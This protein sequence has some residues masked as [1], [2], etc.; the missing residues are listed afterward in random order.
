MI[1]KDISL[2][3]PQENILYDEVLLQLAEEGKSD[4]V[5]RFWESKHYF[6]V[7]GRTCDEN[8]D[9]KR[10]K[11]I[12]DGIPV[13][14]RSSGGGTVIQGPGCLNYSFILSKQKTPEIADLHQSYVYILNKVVSALN[15]LGRNCAFYP[16]S[17]IALTQDRKKVSGNAQKRGR[18]CILHHGT[19]LYYFDLNKIEQYL[20]MP[21]DIPEYREGRNHL[22]FVANLELNAS[23][24]KKELQ[25]SFSI[26]RVE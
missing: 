20:N 3:T 2:A 21:S 12:R 22:D 9:L 5:L 26:Q 1:L 24:I 11:I 23:F 14:R 10:E 17:D 18:N 7:L 6:I 19:L 8:Q 16:I 13:L 25:K 4:Q 15:S